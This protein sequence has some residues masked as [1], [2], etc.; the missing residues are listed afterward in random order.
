MH[1]YIGYHISIQNIGSAIDKL[2]KDKV[3]VAQIFITGNISFA[4][5]NIDNNS[6]NCLKET[7]ENNNITLVVHAPYVINLSNIEPSNFNRCK[8]VILNQL[9]IANKIGAIGIVVHM[10]KRNNSKTK[11]TISEQEGINN[12]INSVSKIIKDYNGKAKL[13]LETAAGQG[14]EICSKIEELSKMF[15]RFSDDERTKLGIC[16]DTC[17]IFAAGHD[18][19]CKKMAKKFY[20]RLN[21]LFNRKDITCIHLNDSKGEVGSKKDRHQDIGQGE[22]GVEGL[23]YIFNKFNKRKVPMVLETPTE[24]ISYLEQIEL[25]ESNS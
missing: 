20:K 18:I 12:F 21:E 16:I 22:I 24:K 15:Y 7:C 19:S 6:L 14:T 25:L 17:H 11:V 13:I 23:R 2:T 8:S 9:E 3:G 5:C 10:G 4:K 1:K